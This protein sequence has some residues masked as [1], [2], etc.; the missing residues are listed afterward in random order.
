MRPVNVSGGR[1]NWRANRIR[2]PVDSLNHRRVSRRIRQTGPGFYSPPSSRSY[3]IEFKLEATN[4]A[5]NLIRD[6]SG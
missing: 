3:A 1:F 6:T 4:S 2:Y 5:L